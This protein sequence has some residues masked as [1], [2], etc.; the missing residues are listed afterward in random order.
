MANI[1]I[2]APEPRKIV[3]EAEQSDTPMEDVQGRGFPQIS[4]SYFTGES[5]K[6][7]NYISKIPLKVKSTSMLLVPETR[8][9][10][11]QTEASAQSQNKQLSVPRPPPKETP[12]MRGKLE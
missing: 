5:L 6:P 11:L 10:Y 9:C 1:T 7:V 8:P 12:F 4:V 2:E 3:Q